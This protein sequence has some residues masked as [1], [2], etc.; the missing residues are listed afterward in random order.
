MCRRMKD[1]HIAVRVVCQHV[2]PLEMVVNPQVLILKACHPGLNA[3]TFMSFRSVQVLQDS[4]YH[5]SS[6]FIPQ[7]S[8]F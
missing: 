6:Q 5:K 3:A 2:K 4:S 8:K 1:V 7:P